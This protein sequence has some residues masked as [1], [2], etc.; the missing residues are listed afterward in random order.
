[1]TETALFA[2]GG[3]RYVRGPFQYSGGVAAE[4]GFGIERVRF[5][6]PLPMVEG[7][8]AIEAHLTA[9]DRPFTAFCACELRSPAP[10]TD[11]GFIAFN[12]VYV[13]TL[14]RWGIFQDEENPV[15][16]SNVCPEID[17]PPEPSF[18]AFCY[19]VPAEP[20]GPNFVIAGSGEATEAPGSY[21]ERIVRLGDTSPEGMREKARFV[22]GAM[23]RRMAALGVGWADASVTQ[24]YTVHD[25]HP[26]LADEIVGRGAAAGGLTWYY[27][28]P[29]VE[30]LDYEMD[31]RGVPVERVIHTKL[32]R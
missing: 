9:L 6:R 10:F 3:Y 31:V 32:R 11:E 15:A 17:P 29:P 26:F 27:A 5:S 13:G 1:M 7:F 18:H 21:A 19:T 22:H 20:T 8:R 12:R 25:V 16:R 30:G 4:P 28:R 24:V 14:E 2:A 23:E